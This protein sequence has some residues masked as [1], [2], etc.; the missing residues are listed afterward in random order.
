MHYNQLRTDESNQ[1][2][3]QDKQFL[4]AL[5]AN[6]LRELTEILQLNPSLLHSVYEGVPIVYLAM[7]KMTIATFRYL[8]NWGFNFAQLTSERANSLHYTAFIE[9]GKQAD[10]ETKKENIEIVNF[11]IKEQGVNIAKALTISGD[12]PLHW[13][14]R[15]NNDELIKYLIEECKC[16]E[17]VVNERGETIFHIA[18]AKGYLSIFKLVEK[19]TIHPSSFIYDKGKE[20]LD[21]ALES[22]QNDIYSYLLPIL[23]KSGNSRFYMQ[24]PS[25]FFA[26]LQS[27][28]IEV[29]ET[30]HKRNPLIFETVRDDNKNIPL[31]Y[32][33]LPSMTVKTLNCLLKHNFDYSMVTAEGANIFHYAALSNIEIIDRLIS[34]NK[35]RKAKGDKKT[36]M[37][38]IKDVHEHITALSNRKTPLD[39]ADERGAED[40]T[41][42]L[43]DF[44]AEE[45]KNI[46]ASSK[47]AQKDLNETTNLAC[48]IGSADNDTEKDGATILN[49]KAVVAEDAALSN[50]PVEQLK[51]GYIKSAA[52]TKSN[53]KDQPALK[54]NLFKKGYQYIKC[55]MLRKSQKQDSKEKN[56]LGGRSGITVSDVKEWN[57][58]PSPVIMSAGP[59]VRRAR[60]W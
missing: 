10:I 53:H 29:L 5:E 22:K 20:L 33:A 25:Y 2:P 52:G 6:N 51:K 9:S 17:R 11:L 50:T 19:I 3:T 26:A 46:A 16:D 37:P 42:Y 31:V 39:W 14:A 8:A 45:E 32:L 56:I 43:A 28:N 15:E 48:N 18:A 57:F 21:L 24:L 27:N 55:T 58:P 40:V 13:C 7:P 34:F 4:I 44:I 38:Y 36:Y 47:I 35:E 23:L 59:K 12:T 54:S 1:L 30:L 49:A 41:R 60:S